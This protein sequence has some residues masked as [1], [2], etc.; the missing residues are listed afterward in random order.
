MFVSQSCHKDNTFFQNNKKKF[1]FFET[2]FA[3][4]PGELRASSP[5]RVSGGPGV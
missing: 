2:F 4:A 1:N 5:V 3:F